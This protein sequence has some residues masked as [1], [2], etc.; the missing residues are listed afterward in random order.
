[1]SC[2][3]GRVTEMDPVTE[4]AQAVLYEGYLLWPYRR[5][6]VKNQHRFTIGGL[7]PRAYALRSHDRYEACFDVLV[8]GAEPAIDLGVRFLQLIHRQVVDDGRAADDVTVDGRRYVSWDET[9]ERTRCGAGGFVFDAGSANEPLS[10]RAEIVRSWARIDGRVELTVARIGD[11]LHRASV[12]IVNESDAGTA[13]EAALAQTLLACHAIVRVD[14]GAFVSTIDPPLE[15]EPEARMCRTEGLWP[16]LVGAP[17]SRDVMLASPI[18]LEEYPEVAA[19]T[20]CD[21]FDGAEIGELLARSIL[22]LTDAERDEMRATDPRGRAIL[23]RV[24]SMTAAE[25]VRLHGG[26]RPEPRLRSEEVPP[27][28]GSTSREL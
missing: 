13:R 27:E 12:R 26:V 8:E 6:A 11:A 25:L 22:A 2:S 18:I 14:D 21:F 23:E 19:E 9:V 7:Y 20:P 24:E 4:I 15:L 10:G 5:S 1:M 17:P 3:T 28:C 16:V